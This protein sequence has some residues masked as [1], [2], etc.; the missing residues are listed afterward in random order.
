MKLSKYFEKK[1]ELYGKIVTVSYN[2]GRTVKSLSGKW[3][4][5]PN[6]KYVRIRDDRIYYKEITDIT[7]GKST[8]PPNE[9]KISPNSINY[10]R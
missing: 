5:D 9:K 2:V 4:G 3:A 6:G 10:N 7:L 1:E 8:P